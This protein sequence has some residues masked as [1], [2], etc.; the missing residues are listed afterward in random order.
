MDT[1]NDHETRSGTLIVQGW[2]ERPHAG[3][4]AVL[5]LV[6][7]GLLTLEISLTRLFSYT[8]W[9]HLAYLTIS[10]ALLG[11]G[12]SGAVV[13]A[14]PK[15]FER[16]GQNRL[17]AFVVAAAVITVM[18]LVLLVHYPLEIS[19]LMAS[20]AK[21]STRL[22][23]Y[24]VAVG[25][26]FLLAG[27][28][29]SAP[30]AAYPR[31]M[32][33]LYFFDLFGAALGC[34]VAVRL[35]EPFG[36]PGLV[37]AAAAIL[38]AGA[39]A[40][41]LGG[42]RRPLGATLAVAAIVL[43]VCAPFWGKSLPVFVTSSKLDLRAPMTLQK[44]PTTA[45]M[46]EDYDAAV[47]RGE[48]FSAWTA[49]NRVDAV[50]WK[51][52]TKLQYW[53][54]VGVA[55]DFHGPYPDSGAITY[56]GSNGSSIYSFR[57][58]FDDYVMLEKHILRTPYLLVEKPN[59][60][61]IGV[62]G[63]IDMINAIKQGA[64]HVT[65]VELQPKT[66]ALLKNHLREFTSGFYH[67]P[68]VT[69]VAGEGRH[70]M[71]KTDQTFDLVEITAVD[72]FSA[73]ATGAYVLAES[74]LY[75]VEAFQDFISRLRPDG[76]LSLIIGGF[77]YPDTLPPYGTRLALNGYRALERMGVADPENHILVVNTRATDGRT[78]SQ[79]VLV[80]RTPFTAEEVAKVKEFA[81]ASGFTILYAPPSISP[82]TYPLATVL[83]TDEAARQEVIDREWFR[84]DPVYDDDPFL[85]NVGKWAN[86][87]RQRD[88]GFVMPGSFVGQ[89]V[90]LLIIGQA[91]VLACV[92][93]PVPLFLG[94]REGLQAR[95]VLSYLVYFLSL[96]VGFM[97]V[98]ISFVQT[99]VLFLGSPTYALS[100]T[101]FSLLL[102]SSIGAFISTRFVDRAVWVLPRLTAAVVM[103]IATY[104]LGLSSIFGAFLHFDLMPRIL[105]AVAAQV[106]IGL[107]LGMFMPIGVACI[108]RHHPRLVP[109]AW[110]VNGIGSVA[111]TTLA[112][113]LAMSWGFAVV[114]ACAALLYII[115]AVLMVR[116]ARAES[117]A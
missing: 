38:L 53:G 88:L 46:I 11:F 80:K 71:R 27:F 98:E 42:G 54:F 93:I 83:G 108:S 113:V 7:M 66:V 102:F 86:F 63:G 92:L 96:G 36:I 76:V 39:A 109:W 59:V 111:G 19:Q 45:K 60:L 8:V 50:G 32:G 25:A 61:V 68:D 110:G 41:C 52:P 43:L 3:I 30:F 6:S 21:F 74:Y 100:V 112:A 5:L 99:F 116:Q 1:M 18:Q 12:A 34:I 9:Y 28:A 57:G 35:I 62:G 13:A 31:Q 48:A 82:G 75:T 107:A 20:P 103:L 17:V 72:T 51:N 49:L 10:V 26:P 89:L 95:G 23:V 22:L 40:L 69:L 67:R 64:S 87:S 114:K 77:V 44:V 101:I 97:F 56:D 91:L 85:Y 90:L 73:Q 2:G 14:Q 117:A 4:Y 104:A 47:Q 94:A 106:P 16:S 37:L 29:I 65:G 84:V 70:F 79:D 58:S 55:P 115:G 24:Y 15:M 78:E 105:I 33:L 81:A